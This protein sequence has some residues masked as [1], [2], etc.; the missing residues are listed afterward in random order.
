M[1]DIYGKFTQWV[2][3]INYKLNSHDCHETTE[4]LGYPNQISQQ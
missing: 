2:I 4:I 1:R 3:I